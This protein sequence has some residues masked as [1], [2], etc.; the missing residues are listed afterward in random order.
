MAGPD[1]LRLPPRAGKPR[2]RGLTHVLDPGRPVGAVD[3]LLDTVADVIDVWKFGWGSAYLDPGLEE[4]VARLTA[5]GVQ[6]STGGTLLEIAWMQGRVDAFLDWAAGLGL[7]LVEVSNGAT[8]MPAVEKRTLIARAAERFEVVGEV[9]SKDPQT[10]VSPALWA[11]EAAG[12]LAAGATRV[13][14]E[15]RES[16]TVGLYRADGEVRWDVA[17][18][19]VEAV[20]GDRV[21]F[22]APRK[23]QQVAFIRRFGPDVSLANVAF[24]DVLGVEALRRG[25]RAD[26][27]DLLPSDTV[28][29]RS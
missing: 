23:A 20:G 8:A 3:A 17:E 11:D 6:P 18:A 2:E 26:T 1:F 5:A 27:L 14:A 29:G 28:G 10:P 16:G 7:P 9:G 22:E 15:G 12:D 19:L 21:V 13:I 25:L 4:K 24:D